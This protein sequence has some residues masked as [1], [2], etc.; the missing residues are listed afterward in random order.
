ME[1]VTLGVMAAALLTKAAE[2]GG[3]D[4]AD[5]AKSA[6][7][8]LAKWLRDRFSSSDDPS[9]LEKLNTAEQITDSERVRAALALAIDDR[10][11]RDGDFAAELARLVNEAVDQGASTAPTIQTAVGNQNVQIAHVSG[12]TIT[13]SS[14][15]APSAN[16]P[17][18]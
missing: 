3:A 12:S 1:P 14:G 2:Q 8:R 11:G 17:A 6:V 18:S 7:G 4:I 16:S 15:S 5:A 13:T 9:E 10:A